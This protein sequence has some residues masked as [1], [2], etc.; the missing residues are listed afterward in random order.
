M[1]YRVMVELDTEQDASTLAEEL[2]DAISAWSISNKD[3]EP[4]VLVVPIDDG[5]T[6]LTWESVSSPT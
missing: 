3:G 2:L 1:K 5:P 4:H 6:E